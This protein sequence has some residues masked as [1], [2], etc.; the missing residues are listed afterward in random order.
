MT[1]F[2]TGEAR[3]LLALTLPDVLFGRAL[4]MEHFAAT[5]C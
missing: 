3:L 4:T 2:P 1:A 5:A